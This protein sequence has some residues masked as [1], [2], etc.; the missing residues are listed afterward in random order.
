MV[1]EP[2]LNFF[3]KLKGE[4]KGLRSFEGLAF[5]S[6][7]PLPLVDVADSLQEWPFFPSLN[8]FPLLKQPS[9]KACFP[10]KIYWKTSS[11]ADLRVLRHSLSRGICILA[12]KGRK[13]L[14]EKK[15]HLILEFQVR[16]SKRV[17]KVIIFHGVECSQR[18]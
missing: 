2:Y 15:E 14:G 5:N 3:L 18:L 13:L 6:L 16:T 9:C 4:K 17:C 12:S 11:S 8:P 7:T 1:C 10:G